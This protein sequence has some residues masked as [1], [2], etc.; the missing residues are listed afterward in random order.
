MENLEAKTTIEDQAELQDE[1]P[2]QSVEDPELPGRASRG[3]K[4]FF[5]LKSAKSE[6][7]ILLWGCRPT[8]TVLANTKM[9]EDIIDEL[10]GKI[11]PTMLT[12]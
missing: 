2:N 10:M 8:H 12:V 6:N 11:D 9:I 4:P 3:S 7:L 1:E 5:T